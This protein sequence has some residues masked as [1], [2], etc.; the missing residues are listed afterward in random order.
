MYFFIKDYELLEIF[1]TIWN[2]VSNSIRN[3]IANSSALKKFLETKVKSCGR[4]ATDYIIKVGS[5]YTCLA[6]IFVDFV[7]NKKT[8]VRNV[9]KRM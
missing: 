7:K 2:N 1:N 9:F 4:E 6:V 5:N 3:L 8:I